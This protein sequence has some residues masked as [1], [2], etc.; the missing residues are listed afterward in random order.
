ILYRMVS[1]YWDRRLQVAVVADGPHQ[2]WFRKI[3]RDFD[4]E[5]RVAVVDFDEKLSRLAY[6][7]A[8]FV[9]VPSLFEPCGLAQ[10][11]AQR[12]GTLPVV[13]A[14]GGLHDTVRDLDVESSTGNGFSFDRYESVEL[15]AAVD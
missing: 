9:L 2:Q 10:M 15:R 14:T 6:A 5:Q 12:Y 11:I 1:D 3:V 13:H 8:D 4:L 7:G